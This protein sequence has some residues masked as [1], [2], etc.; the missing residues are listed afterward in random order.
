MLGKFDHHLMLFFES[1]LKG[2]SREYSSLF[3]NEVAD[4]GLVG[5][6]CSNSFPWSIGA[7]VLS[8]ASTD[9]GTADHGT[10]KEKHE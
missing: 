3:Q 4:F 8:Q 10:N 5:S 2:L 7:K 9:H 6:T 1:L